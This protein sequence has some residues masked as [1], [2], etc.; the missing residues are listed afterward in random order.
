MKPLL[1]RFT[2]GRGADAAP[3]A[4]LIALVLDHRDCQHY[5]ESALYTRI[6]ESSSATVPSCAE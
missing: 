3:C 1:L 6:Y 2:Q 4:L 5:K